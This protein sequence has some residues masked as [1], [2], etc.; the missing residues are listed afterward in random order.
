MRVREVKRRW[1]LLLREVTD[2]ASLRFPTLDWFVQVHR[3]RS[4][5][6]LSWGRPVWVW[7]WLLTAPVSFPHL[8]SY[9]FFSTSH[10]RYTKWH[11]P[12]ARCVLSIMKDYIDSTFHLHTLTPQL[13][14]S[15]EDPLGARH[16]FNHQGTQEM[17]C[18]YPHQQE[19]VCHREK[20]RKP[21]YNKSG[22]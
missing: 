17:R 12:G 21:C 16:H 10:Y 15:A 18:G 8:D 11:S 4:S 5:L 9:G 2:T 13:S 6:G 1:A 7:G 14:V 19:R 22:I 20:W 3:G